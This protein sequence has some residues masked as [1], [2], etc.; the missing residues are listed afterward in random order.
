MKEEKRPIHAL[1]AVFCAVFTGLIIAGAYIRLDFFAV[2]VTLQ[3]QIVLLAGFL[4]G[5][6]LAAVSASAYIFLGLLGLPVFARGGGIAYIFQP[7]FGY[8]IGFVFASF[9]VGKITETRKVLSTKVYILAAFT[10][11]AIVY[12]IGVLYLYLTKRFYIKEAVGV[13]YIISNGFLITFPTDLVMSVGCI[14]LA[15]RLRPPAQ[16]YLIN[17]RSHNE[18]D[19]E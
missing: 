12:F 15:R 7:T 14:M 1:P 4:L 10:G 17:R 2:P 8:L 9:A 19:C 11:L 5:S 16:Q 13:W 6:R 3:L 18:S